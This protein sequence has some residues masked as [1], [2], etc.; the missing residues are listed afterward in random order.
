MGFFLD[1]IFSSIEKASTIIG[2]CCD[3]KSIFIFLRQETIHSPA[4]AG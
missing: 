4:F 1:A 3:K 2:F